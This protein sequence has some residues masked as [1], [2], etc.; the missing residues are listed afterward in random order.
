MILGS[1]YLDD[2]ECQKDGMS[3]EWEFKDVSRLFFQKT[4]DIETLKLHTITP[5]LMNSS[6]FI[7]KLKLSP[8]L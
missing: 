5:F 7:E 4:G 8:N 2:S 6:L 3:Q 1:S